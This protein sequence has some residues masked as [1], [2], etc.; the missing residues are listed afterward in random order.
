MTSCVIIDAAA[1]EG[2]LADA[3]ELMDRA[4]RAD[5][6]EVAD[7]DVAGQ[8]GVVGEDRVRADV[9]VV[10]DVRVGH[11]EVVDPIVVMPPPPVVPR[12][13][14]TN[15][16]KMLSLPM[17]SSVCSPL[18]F[19]SCGGPADRGVTVELIALADR[20]R[21]F[22]ARERTDDAAAADGDVRRR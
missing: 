7:L 8:R 3:A 22:D 14:V 10:R 5:R 9:A 12:L 20:G 1:D 18:Y 17:A 6:G 2:V 19:R 16:R 13:I 21:A 11:E 4:E 15:S